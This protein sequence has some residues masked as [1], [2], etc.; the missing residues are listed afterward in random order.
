MK[1]YSLSSA[2]AVLALLCL[3][4]C[5]AQD[6]S[7]TDDMIV[8]APGDE[9]PAPGDNSPANGGDSG[10]PAAPVGGEPTPEN[11]GSGSPSQPGDLPMD[12]PVEVECPE[13]QNRVD[14]ACVPV[15]LEGTVPAEIIERISGTYAVE[16]R[17]V[18]IQSVPILGDLDNVSTV[19]GF[20]EI[21]SDGEGGVVMVEHGCGAQSAAGDTI[22]VVIPAAIPRSVT[23][24]VTPLNVWE[25]NGVVHWSR[26]TVVVPI[27]VRLEDPVNDP[28]P[29]DPNDPRIWDQDEDGFPGVT[30]NVSGFAT[31]DLYIIQKQISSEHGIVN[32]AGELEGFIV[33]DSEQYTIGG[34][35]PLLNQQIPSRPNPDRSLSTLRSARMAGAM[36]CDWLLEN[37]DQVFSSDN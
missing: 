3:S 34:T 11:P 24:P 25:E 6:D 16:M 17:I 2:F 19:L 13:G 31:G 37:Q 12:P 26:P 7:T 30:V 29:M 5:G 22:S 28:L 32:E 15:D 27:G 21:T 33:D 8:G 36:D 10:E 18:M 23:P 4:A 35:N 1:F 20:T 14:G 9:Q